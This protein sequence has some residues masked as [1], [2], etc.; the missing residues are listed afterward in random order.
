MDDL[1][2]TQILT[3]QWPVPRTVYV[4]FVEQPEKGATVFEMPTLPETNIFE[5]ENGWLED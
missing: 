2:A 3:D 4:D 5:P 1:C